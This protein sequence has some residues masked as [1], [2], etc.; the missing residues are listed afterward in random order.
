MLFILQPTKQLPTLPPTPPQR[1]HY[2]AGED[3]TLACDAD[4]TL[5]PIFH[6][7]H[8]GNYVEQVIKSEDILHPTTFD[9]IEYLLASSLTLLCLTF[10]NIKLK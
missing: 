9:K 1:T 8:N 5:S 4:G 7:L 3:I 2:T 10:I 6:W